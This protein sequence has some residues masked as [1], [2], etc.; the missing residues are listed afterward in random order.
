MPTPRGRW[1]VAVLPP[2]YMGVEVQSVR[3]LE[4]TKEGNQ[5]KGIKRRESKEGNQ[6]KGIKRREFSKI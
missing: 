3:D 2:I 6:K 4:Q 5:K 1:H